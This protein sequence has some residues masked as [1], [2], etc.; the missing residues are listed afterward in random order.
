MEHGRIT[1]GRQS[2][3]DREIAEGL[4]DVKKGRTYGPYDSA[5]EMLFSISSREIHSSCDEGRSSIGILGRFGTVTVCI[6]GAGPW[7][8]RSN[9]SSGRPSSS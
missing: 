7:M 5:D 8:A 3:V 4:A 9:G 1:L 6:G 2:L